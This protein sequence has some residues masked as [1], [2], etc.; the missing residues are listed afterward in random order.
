MRHLNIGLLGLGTV[1]GGVVRLLEQ[2][3]EIIER[4]A[5]AALQIA[6]ILV[7]NPH[8]ARASGIS[9]DL[10][11]TTDPNDILESD[12][13]DI[14]VEVMGSIE[15]AR[16]YLLRALRAGKTVVTANKDL[17]A[18]YGE[19]LFAAAEEG[20]TEIFYEA[21]VGG[22][23][24]IIR[25]LK[26]VLAAN[27][28][29]S[30]LGI[31]NGTT[32]YILTQMTQLGQSYED[33]LQEAQDLGYAEPD[34]TADVEGHD[35]ARKLAILASIG[36]MTKIVP[37]QVYTEGISRISATDIAYGKRMGWTIK[38]LAIGKLTGGQVEV[39]VHPAFLPNSHPLASVHGSFNAIFVRG[40]AMGESM[41]Y[42]RGAGSLPTASSVLG[43]VI[44]AAQ[45]RLA[46]VPRASNKSTDLFDLPIRDVGDVACCYYVRLKVTDQPGVLAKVADAFGVSGVSIA[47]VT[48]T[49][50]GPGTGVDEAELL[51]VTHAVEE[52]RIREVQRF[53]RDQPEVGSIASMIRM[54]GIE[55]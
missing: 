49:A 54:E 2:N 29:E 3:R 51:L 37:D 12:D 23:I 30:V 44:A 32:N 9:E 34:P 31:L 28:I 45:D 41:L 43:D 55:Q 18:E 16:T 42:G 38:L 20:N 48:Q 15:P 11:L 26:E 50:G 21:A 14:V 33:A 52:R 39:R 35:V 10:P 8:K 1:G 13:I 53:L 4:K 25:S 47:S 17:I 6:R 36:F 24:P 7:R 5:G 40:D 19:E 27:R 22:A 46:G